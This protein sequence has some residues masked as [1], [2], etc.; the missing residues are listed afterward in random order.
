MAERIDVFIGSTS[1]DLTAYRDAATKVILRLG[2]HPIIME[3]F[4]PT[5]RNALQL[6]YDYV[7][8]AEIFVGIYA[9]RYGYSPDTDVT[10]LRLMEKV[11]LVMAKPVLPIWNTYGQR[12]AI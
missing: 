2:L 11:A 1:R 6:C 5:D 9:Y 8:E 4:N 10:L 12:S 7:K 3:A